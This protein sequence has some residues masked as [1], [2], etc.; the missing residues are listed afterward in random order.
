MGSVFGFCGMCQVV[1][2]KVFFASSWVEP[3]F[4]CLFNKWRELCIKEASLMVVSH[5]F[6]SILEETVLNFFYPVGYTDIFL[7]PVFNYSLFFFEPWEKN[8][9]GR[10]QLY[11]LLG[12]ADSSN[13]YCRVS[14]IP[15]GEEMQTLLKATWI[16]CYLSCHL[17]VILPLVF[18][19]QSVKANVNYLCR[20]G[21]L[22][23][24][25]T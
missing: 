24:Y 5:R 25:C 13:L 23:R 6:W 11:V 4:F 19:G 8:K 10:I 21:C 12:F 22:W 15:H 17:C 2:D 7:L 1:I 18:C 9:T 16:S 3:A 20:Q 14:Q